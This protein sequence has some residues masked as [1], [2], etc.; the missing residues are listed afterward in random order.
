MYL[1]LIDK[2]KKE[3]GFKLFH[4]SLLHNHTHLQVEVGEKGSVSAIMHR[5][6]GEFARWYNFMH[7]RKGHFWQGRFKSKLIM[8]ENYFLRCGIYINLNAVRA[9]LVKR[10]QDWKYSSAAAYLGIDKND[11]IDISPFYLTLGRDEAER[12]EEYKR[13]MFLELDRSNAIKGALDKEDKKSLRRLLRQNSNEP[14]P[15]KNKVKKLLG[16][17]IKNCQMVPGT[18]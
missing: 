2:W 15:F 13:L 1:E 10:P 18:N 16:Y 6:N 4:Y 9:N 12:G 3:F 8:D 7:N 11:L 5:I 17:R 14:I